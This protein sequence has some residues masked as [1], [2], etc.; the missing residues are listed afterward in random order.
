MC[1]DWWWSL[2]CAP[3]GLSREILRNYDGEPCGFAATTAKPSSSVRIEIPWAVSQS[4]S[5]ARGTISW[6]RL[7]PLLKL[8][9]ITI[10]MGYVRYGPIVQ[11]MFKLIII[12]NLLISHLQNTHG[13]SLAILQDIFLWQDMYCNYH[14][15][16]R[17]IG[18]LWILNSIA[19]CSWKNCKL[20]TSFYY[21]SKRGT[22]ML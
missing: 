2:A 18:I 21:E 15:D 17:V 12:Q 4:A 1:W 3:S 8:T 19:S 22:L 5:K 6:R 10:R 9:L 14:W 11:C 20:M 16:N 13:Y 7:R